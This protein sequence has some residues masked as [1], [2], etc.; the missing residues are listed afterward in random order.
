[1]KRAILLV[2]A[3]LA[4]GLRAGAQIRTV[5]TDLE[6]RCRITVQVGERRFVTVDPSGRF[7]GME[8]RGRHEYYDSFANRCKQGKLKRLDGV[9]FDYYDSF[10]NSD[11]Q[12]RIKRIGDVVF[13]YYDSFDNDTRRGRLKRIGT[14][15]LDYYDRFDND[16][17]CGKIKRIGSVEFDYYD[18]FAPDYKCGRLA[19]IG[20]ERFDYD[21]FDGEVRPVCGNPAFDEDGI[22]FRVRGIR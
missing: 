1:M 10:D 17:K 7:D 14:V 8:W 9:E 12:G 6:G 4:V 5:R 16:A 18:T 20:G 2:C 13:D 22:R 15:T 3:A 19:R 11:K 21:A